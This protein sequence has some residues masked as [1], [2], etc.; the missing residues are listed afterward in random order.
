MTVTIQLQVKPEFNNVYL[1]MSSPIYIRA[2]LTHILWSIT[3]F[4]LNF[5]I[6]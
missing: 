3:K 5:I 2:L 4:Y 6:L 1:T